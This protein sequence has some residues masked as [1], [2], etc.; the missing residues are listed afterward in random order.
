MYKNTIAANKIGMEVFN[1]KVEN[2][3][4]GIQ[5]FQANFINKSIFAILELQLIVD[6]QIFGSNP[7]LILHIEGMTDGTGNVLSINLQVYQLV[8]FVAEKADDTLQGTF[9]GIRI[10]SPYQLTIPT[11]GFDTA[12]SS[13]SNCT[14][15]STR[16]RTLCSANG[17]TGNEAGNTARSYSSNNG[18][19]NNQGC[20]DGN[21]SPVGQRP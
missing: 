1:F 14:T 12:L 9:T 21:L 18:S 20:T 13:T 19:A 10:F 11:T 3:H 15:D 4:R 2:L 7:A 8:L 16:D 6:M 17:C 5:L